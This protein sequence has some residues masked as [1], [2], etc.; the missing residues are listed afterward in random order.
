MALALVGQDL[1]LGLVEQDLSLGLVG[2]KFSLIRVH[3]DIA[4]E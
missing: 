1:S 4:W 3:T 2:H